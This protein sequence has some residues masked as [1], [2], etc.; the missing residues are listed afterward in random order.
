MTIGI[1]HVG[2]T[3][4]GTGT[5]KTKIGGASMVL[6]A[7]A[8]SILA[9]IPIM[10]DITPT[11]VQSI[12]ARVD[13]ESS[14]VKNLGP[15]EVLT[16]PI[17]AGLGATFNTLTGKDEWLMGAPCEG[18][19]LVDIYG[20]ALVAN[21]VAPKMQC[22]VVISDNPPPFAQRHAKLG[23]LTA[24]GTTADTDVAG[25]KYSFSGGRRIVELAGMYHPKTIAAGDAILGY[26]KYN[27]S[28]F[29]QT[30]P[31]ELPL[32]PNSFGLGATGSM[33]IPGVSRQKTDIAVKTGQVNIQDYLN[34]HLLPASAGSWISGVVFE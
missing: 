15:F 13:V 19:E 1:T 30:W 28:E 22:F 12:S 27:S 18:G 25:T 8:R 23:T 33:L 24:A 17:G 16:S 29:V 21:T 3:S 2:A 34:C 7:D 9:I 4:L 14:D 5:T 20:T 10:A 6:P 31:Y 26:I 11:T 32:S